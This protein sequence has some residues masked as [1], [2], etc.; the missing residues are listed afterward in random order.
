M[1]VNSDPSDFP[2][3][4]I[5][6]K[7]PVPSLSVSFMDCYQIFRYGKPNVEESTP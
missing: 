4:M 6:Q 2:I 7:M 3:G 1:L 5:F